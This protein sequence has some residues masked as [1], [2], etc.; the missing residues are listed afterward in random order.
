MS[1]MKG[2]FQRLERLEDIHKAAKNFKTTNV[3]T[4]I[5][6]KDSDDE[7]HCVSD[8]DI[9]NQLDSDEL[10]D[11]ETPHKWRNLVNQWI[12]MVE[13]NDSEI[14]LEQICDPE[15]D[16]S[17]EDLISHDMD[18]NNIVRKHHPLS[19]RKAKWKLSDIFNFELLQP[20]SY[21]E[22]LRGIFLILHFMYNII[23][24]L[25]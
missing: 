22:S 5:V 13:E 24:L 12:C 21:L 2:E 4:P 1:Q 3:A 25:Y 7:L 18:L 15:D 8:D 17:S 20:P 16:V 23:N 11:I 14:S 9:L 10:G 19:N 6:Q